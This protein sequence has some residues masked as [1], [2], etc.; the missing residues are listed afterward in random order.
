MNKH[1]RQSF[2]GPS[3]EEILKSL[4]VAIV[5]LGGGGSHIAQQLAHVGV[6]NLYLFDFD[7]IDKEGS[8]LNRLVGATEADVKAGTLKVEI[9][10]RLITGIDSTIK[11]F[12]FNSSWQ[13]NHKILRQCDVIFG[14]VDSLLERRDLEAAARRFLIPYIDIGMDVHELKNHFV[15]GGQVVLSM[16]G[17]PCMRCLGILREDNLAAEAAKYGAAGSRP[18]VIWSNGVLASAAVGV[19]IQ[20]VTPWGAEHSRTILL[21]YDGNSQTVKPSNKLAYLNDIQC[22]HYSMQ[23]ELGDPFLQ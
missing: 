14:C 17:Q 11:V 5:G 1:Q 6:G 13:D 10:K 4:R 20:M 19:L 18:Q 23:Q 22:P 9:A 8:N 16:P 21:E 15:I 2:L 7:V 12:P 3:S